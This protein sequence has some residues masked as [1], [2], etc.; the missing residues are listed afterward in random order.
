MKVEAFQIWQG[1]SGDGI[2][3]KRTLQA[4]LQRL[5]QLIHLSD[6]MMEELATV[7]HYAKSSNN[8]SL[9]A[10]QA[11]M[12][13]LLL[14]LSGK[15]EVRRSLWASPAIIPSLLVGGALIYQSYGSSSQVLSRSTNQCL[16][17]LGRCN[18]RFKGASNE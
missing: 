4:R 15:R 11:I 7:T 14:W 6:V 8:P 16:R 10:T 17:I 1:M 5:A 12:Y 3:G 9:E 2:A 13:L 18:D